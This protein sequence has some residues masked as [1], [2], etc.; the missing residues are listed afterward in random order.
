[1][2]PNQDGAILLTGAPAGV[3]GFPQSGPLVMG[4]LALRE[5][6]QSLARE[7]HSQGNPSGPLHGDGAIRIRGRTEPPDIAAEPANV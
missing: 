4:K 7:L 2:L 6:A 5:L 1:M 3:K